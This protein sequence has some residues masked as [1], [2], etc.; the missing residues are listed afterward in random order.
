MEIDEGADIGLQLPNGGVNTSLNLLS[1]EFSKPALNLIDPGC[2]SRREVDM[3][4]WPTGEPGFDPR[5][6]VSG[7]VV[8]DDMN[9]EAVRNLSI[10]LFEEL[11]ELDGPVALVASADDEPR[12]DIEGGKQ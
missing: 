4:M 9:I 7:V 1:G 11:Q 8:H 12:G 5:R 3:I 2:G 10:D 6:F